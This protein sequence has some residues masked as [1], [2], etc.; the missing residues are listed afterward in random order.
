MTKAENAQNIGAKMVIIADNINE[1]NK[2][3]M[4]DDGRGRLI[5]IPSL[6]IN[7]EDGQKLQNLIEKSP[8]VNIVMKL[9]VNRT[10]IAS[11]HFWLSACKSS[12]YAA[13]RQTY[14][15][16][17]EFE[18]YYEKL[19]GYI[20]MNISYYSVECQGCPIEDCFQ[21]DTNFCQID[22][23]YRQSAKGAKII[24]EQFRQY[25]LFKSNPKKWFQYM[26]MFD[27]R[28][29]SWDEAEACSASIM[30]ELGTIP[31]TY[32]NKSDVL[33]AWS[34]EMV[35]ARV[36]NVPDATVNGEPYRGTVDADDLVEM[37]C[38]SLKERPDGCSSFFAVT[39]PKSSSL[40]V[41]LAVLTTLFIILVIGGIIL[42]FYRRNVKR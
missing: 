4:A 23:I 10:S 22:G 30:N 12:L 18:P 25:G 28:C 42:M 37:V 15:L 19:K 32:S 27:K 34:G 35:K 29:F 33:A 2:I 1:T 14:I 26:D 24:E 31:I 17:R 13:S 41:A 9:E 5:H 6:F 8:S 16:M 38:A 39:A 11:V 20:R 36:Y 3:I 7:F 21:G 40:T